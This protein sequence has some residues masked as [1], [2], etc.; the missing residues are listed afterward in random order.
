MVRVQQPASQKH[1]DQNIP[2]GQ[3]NMIQDPNELLNT[4]ST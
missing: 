2:V 1:Q 4:R 3:L